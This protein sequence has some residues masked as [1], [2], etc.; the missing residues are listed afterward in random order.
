MPSRLRAA[1]RLSAYLAWTLALIPIQFALLWL[2][3]RGAV[4]FPR[5]YHRSCCRII[6]LKVRVTGRPSDACPTLFVANHISYLDITAL[7]AVVAGSFI[8][9]TEVGSWP[10]Y[11]V[12]ARLQR[13]VFVERRATRTARHR[14][15]IAERLAA[16]DRLVL[17]A[18]GTNSDGAHVLP[19][20]SS[21]FA[22]ASGGI[23]VQPVS[24]AYTRIDGAVLGRWLRPFVAYYGDMTLASHLVGLVGLG[25]VTADI[26]FHPVVTIEEVGSRKAL[27]RLCEGRVSA[28]VSAAL[29]GRASQLVGASS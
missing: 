14:D 22:A 18:E 17:F 12:L 5:W 28:G 26:V 27:A 11:G 1:L 6:G 9:K 15:E 23:A 25:A 2:S 4:A 21:F 16:G 19:F 29:A 10:L 13:T 20:R 7:G 24:I 8:A 3:P